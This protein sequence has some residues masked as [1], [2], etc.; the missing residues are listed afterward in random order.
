MGA[1]VRVL[2]FGTYDLHRHPRAGIALEGLRQSGVEVV[3]LNRPLGFSTAERVAMLG[4]PWLAYRLV[5]RILARWVA[6]TAG[7]LR[8]RREG[9]PDA[10]LVGYLGHFD[11]VLARLLFPRTQIVLDMMIFAADTASDRGVTGGIKLRLLDALDRLAVRC[12][13]VV[14][15]DTDEHR[16]LVPEAARGKAV[17]VPVGAPAAWF[18]AGDAAA[19]TRAAAAGEAGGEPAADEPAALRVAFFGLFTPLQGAIVIGQ[20]LALLADR[21]DI[22]VTMIGTGQ[23]HAACRAAAAANRSVTWLDWVE[24]DELPRIVAGHDVCLGIFGTTPKALRVVPNKVYQGAAAGCAIVTSDTPPQRRMLGDAAA[25]VPPGDPAAL[26]DALRTLGGDAAR[27][28]QLGAAARTLATSRF[29][30]SAIVEPLSERLLRRT[31]S[32]RRPS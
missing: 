6:L 20:A 1:R 14:M 26:A 22:A 5:L 2:G 19:E 23:D 12:A 13:D 18:A 24:P 32:S 31:D 28:R 11:V 7:S 15:V 29:A 10:V 3:D 17:I 25:Y 27:T 4:K 21:G 16:E 9:R 8:V 30:A